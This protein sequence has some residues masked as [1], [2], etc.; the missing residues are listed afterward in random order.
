MRCLEATMYH[1]SRVEPEPLADIM[2]QPYR[3][4]D[5]DWRRFVI[6][7]FPANSVGA[8]IGVHHGDFSQVI[9]DVAAPVQLHLIDP[10][11]HESS[12]IYQ[13][14]W[15]GGQAERGQVEMD[16]RYA[17]V[18]DRFAASIAAQRV[19]I[20]RGQSDEVIAALPD[21]SLDWVYI[22]GNHLYEFVAKDLALSLRK[23][24]RG[25]LI[26]GDDYVEGGWWKGGVKRAV[27]EFITT[28]S[29]RVLLIANEQYVLKR[30]AL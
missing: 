16:E 12:A 9:L 17:G 25:G 26:S 7:M 19:I 15:Y 13:D 10:W 6:E 28:A 30:A 20:H 2:R 4:T 23:V 18:L 11:R 27:D 1:S 3:P 5:A 29:V 14:A 22:D 8:E 24:R 21:D